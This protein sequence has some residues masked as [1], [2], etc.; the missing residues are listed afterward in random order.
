[1]KFMEK[2]IV[3]YIVPHVVGM[4]IPRE[5]SAAWPLFVLSHFKPFGI[6][7]PLVLPEDTP[8]TIFD[9][10][11]FSCNALTIMKNWNAIYECEDEH[12]AECL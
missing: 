1:M 3:N 5:T 7:N 9:T 2:D 11:N 12:D 10:Y 8:N 4:S 6:S